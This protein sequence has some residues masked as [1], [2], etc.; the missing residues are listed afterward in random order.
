VQYHGSA[1]WSVKRRGEL[2][3]L[4]DSSIAQ[5][6]FIWRSPALLM[7]ALAVELQHIDETADRIRELQSH[8]ASRRAHW[9]QLGDDLYRKLSVSLLDTREAETAMTLCDERCELLKSLTE[10]QQFRTQIPMIVGESDSLQQSL[11]AVVEHAEA[12][13]SRSLQDVDLRLS[14]YSVR[15][16][17]SYRIGRSHADSECSGLSRLG[18]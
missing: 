18:D 11:L 7:E 8:L 2:N 17:Q 16:G 15:A 5:A 9:S 14:V 13:W 4:L 3:T 12:G 6:E 1:Q 10:V